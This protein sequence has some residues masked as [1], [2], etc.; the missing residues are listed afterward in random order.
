MGVILIVDLAK[1]HI[2]S[3]LRGGHYTTDRR[4]RQ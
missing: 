3:L 4:F 1:R 2:M